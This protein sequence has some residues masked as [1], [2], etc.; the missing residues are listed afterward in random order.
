MEELI[1]RSLQGDQD[2]YIELI[3]SIQ[4]EMYKIATSQLNNIDDVN[5]AIQETIMHSYDKLHT[6]KNFNYFKTWIIRILINECNII[7]R[8]RKKTIRSF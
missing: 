8:N 4:V 6:L 7:H 5:D 2:A 1:K 3:E